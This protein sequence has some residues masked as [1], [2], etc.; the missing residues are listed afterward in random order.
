MCGEGGVYTSQIVLQDVW[1]PLDRLH[2]VSDSGGN[3]AGPALHWDVCV[4]G[5]VP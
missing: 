2:E 1:F 3:G 5:L 4:G